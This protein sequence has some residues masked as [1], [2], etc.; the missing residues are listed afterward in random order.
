MKALIVDDSQLAR[1]E[2]KHLLKHFSHVHIIG[3]AENAEQALTLIEEKQPQLLF[4]DIQMPDKDGFELLEEL[5]DVP[6]V[7]FTTA[8]D[9]YA[10]Q[11][12]DHNA[13]DYLQKPIKEERLSLALERA[14]EKIRLREEKES[15]VKLLGLSSQVFVKD[16]EQCWFVS[17]ANVRMMEIMGSYT[18]IFFNNQQPMIP[19]SLNYMESRLDPEV[20]FRANRQ[21]IINLKY[22]DRI[23]PWFS[24]TL[25]LYLKGGEEVEVSRRQSIRFR[26]IMSF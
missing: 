2:L 8:F 9:Q 5:I 24:G 21:Q 19:R 22:I 4:L 13:L 26:E 11:A 14:S 1:Q 20:F 18:R 25:K 23:E 7:I 15:K 17:L 16:G 10:M 3:E 12:F 6:E